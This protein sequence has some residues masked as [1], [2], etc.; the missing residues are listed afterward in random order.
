MP[1][2]WENI[3]HILDN[4]FASPTIKDIAISGCVALKVDKESDKF[5][6]ALINLFN[7]STVVAPFKRGSPIASAK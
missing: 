3:L 7:C 4:I 2:F 6:N 1:D 5:I